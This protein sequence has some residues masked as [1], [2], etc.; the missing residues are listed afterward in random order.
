LPEEKQK[1]IDIESICEL[2]T[3]VLG[4][5]FPAQ[6]NLFV[7]YLKVS[8]GFYTTVSVLTSDSHICLLFMADSK[9]LQG[10]KHGSMDG[11]FPLLQWGSLFFCYFWIA[12]MLI[13]QRKISLNLFS[14]KVFSI[15]CFVFKIYFYFFVFEQF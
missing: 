9:W 13:I 12:Y 3:L 10:H 1:S 6:V 5:T 4:S 14:P 2:L 7:E 8:N 11:I 15:V